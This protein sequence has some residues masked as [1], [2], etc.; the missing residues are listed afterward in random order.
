LRKKKETAGKRKGKK[1]YKTLTAKNDL[2][3]GA[4][5]KAAREAYTYLK[6]VF[7]SRVQ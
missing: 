7:T 6:R 4:F 1:E 2:R 5:S 3:G